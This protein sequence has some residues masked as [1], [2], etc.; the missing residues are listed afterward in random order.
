ML[1]SQRAAATSRVLHRIT[2]RRWQ[3]ARAFVHGKRFVHRSQARTYEHD[4][5]Y[6]DTRDRRRPTEAPRDAPRAGTAPTGRVSTRQYRPSPSRRVYFRPVRRVKRDHVRTIQGAQEIMHDG[7]A[8][9]TIV[10][11][12]IIPEWAPLGAKCV[13]YECLFNIF[14]LLIIQPSM[15]TLPHKIALTMMDLPASQ[16]LQ[17]ARRIRLLHRHQAVP[18]CARVIT[19]GH[20]EQPSRLPQVWREQDQGRSCAAESLCTL[21]FMTSGPRRG[22]QFVNVADNDGLDEQGFAPIGRLTSPRWCRPLR[23]ATTAHHT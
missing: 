4:R 14:C 5:R 9:P 3:R 2:L 6:S 19:S 8:A 22:S 23:A 11:A 20:P 17:G 10:E 15:P 13:R 7:A 21:C 1:P 12:E 18:C 16:A